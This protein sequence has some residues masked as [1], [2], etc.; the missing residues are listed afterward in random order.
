MNDKKE[1]LGMGNKLT[2]VEEKLFVSFK[3]A[4]QMIM[5]QVMI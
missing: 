3:V 5:M 4:L 2:L 1:W